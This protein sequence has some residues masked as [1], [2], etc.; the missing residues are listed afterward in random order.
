[1][2]T[3][4]RVPAAGTGNEVVGKVVIL[5]GT[6]K[7]ISP[8]GTIRLLMPNSPIFANDRIVTES[9]GNVSVMFDG[10]PPTQMD[11]GRMSNVVVDE[12]VYAG[13][14][15]SVASD[16]AAEA[17]QIQKALMAGDQP[18]DLEATAAGGDTGV[19]GG[20]P[21][22]V[23]DVTGAEV[24]PTSGA[25]TIG[26]TYGTTGTLESAFTQPVTPVNEAPIAVNDVAAAN[27]ALITAEDTP[28]TIAAA[29]LTGNDSDPDGDAFSIT[30]FTQT[31]HGT[32]AQNSDGSFTYTP[33]LNYNGSDSFTYTITDANGASATATVFINVTPVNDPPIAVNDVAAT[34]DAL[35]TAEDTPLT[36]AAAALT[37]N[38]SD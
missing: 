38:D 28:L 22:F 35:V 11:L 34:N 30:G 7:A 4:T 10:T 2:A 6:V 24:T 36:I 27:D 1:M 12:D 32:L 17:E 25:G 26:V 3:N 5:Y 18:I 8:D 15:S 29:A 33:E 37:G 19:G 20:H 31:G 16:A 14:V 9:D 23:V 13:G 21:V